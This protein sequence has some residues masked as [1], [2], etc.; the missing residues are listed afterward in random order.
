MMPTGSLLRTSMYVGLCLLILTIWSPAIG[1]AQGT[2]TPISDTASTPESPWFLIDKKAGTFTDYESG[3]SVSWN[4]DF[5][6]FPHTT[7]NGFFG[8]NATPG[9][10]RF[11]FQARVVPHPGEAKGQSWSLLDYADW[12]YRDP[13][14]CLNL[15]G[16]DE[17]LRRIA[18]VATG[19]DGQPMRGSTDNRA[20]VVLQ[21][22]SEGDMLYIEC[23][24]LDPGSSYLLTTLYAPSQEA[25]NI[26]A[27]ELEAL[28][29]SI[30][31]AEPG[32]TPPP[33]PAD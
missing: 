21:Y 2:S 23:R 13:S 20:W 15:G 11:I 4:P 24:Y 5:W 8:I 14:E 12:T 28:L 1:A 22:P 32:G 29:S 33:S 26:V 9:T 31:I 7:G 17:A 10:D 27:P 19:A 30:R 16:G 6:E 3:W 18:D 25:F